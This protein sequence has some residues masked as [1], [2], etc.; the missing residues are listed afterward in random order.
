MLSTIGT[1]VWVTPHIPYRVQSSH[2][3]MDGTSGPLSNQVECI[4]A[5]L[6]ELQCLPQCHCQCGKALFS[7]GRALHHVLEDEVRSLREADFGNEPHGNL[8]KI[9]ASER[10]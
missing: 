2:M 1:Q 10:R 9:H 3:N 8:C 4:G 7:R 5:I 6:D